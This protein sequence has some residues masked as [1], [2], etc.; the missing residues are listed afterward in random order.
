[1]TS[2][3]SIYQLIDRLDELGNVETGRGPKHATSPNDELT[4]E[5]ADFLDTYSF[6][7]KDQS[8]VDFLESY[9]GLLLFRDDDFF[10]LGI[11]GFDEDVS[12]HLVEG[13][14]ELIDKEGILA[15][16]NLTLPLQEADQSADNLRGIAFGFDSTQQK[17]W[18]V[19]RSID[20]QP[21]HWY[22]GSF[23][24]WL[25]KLY[26]QKGRLLEDLH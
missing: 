7:S 3:N 19:Y 2:N 13:E 16:A 26:N 21:Y 9:A 22:C 14:G 5:I 17:T 23:L 15:F 1:M 4:Q 12:L 18:G 11:F 10:S 6:L 24:E 25:E 20:E 8:Y